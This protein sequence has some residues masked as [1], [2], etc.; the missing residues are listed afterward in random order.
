MAYRDIGYVSYKSLEKM[1][2]NRVPYR[3]NHI[4]AWP[5]G[6]RDYSDRHFRYDED[7]GVY[8]LYLGHLKTLDRIVAGHINALQYE[9]DMRI[10]KS[11]HVGR[12][13][14]DN[15]FE[16]IG[17]YSQGNF[18]FYESAFGINFYTQSSI[19][20]ATMGWRDD[21]YKTKMHPIFHGLRV[22]TETKE[23]HPSTH[24]VTLHPTLKVKEAKEYTK[25]FKEFLDVH[26][27]FLDPLEANGVAEIV[28]D[29]KSNYLDIKNVAG[30]VEDL[31]YRKL[32]ADAAVMCA[33]FRS[34]WTFRDPKTSARH[35]KFAARKM[36]ESDGAL[37]FKHMLYEKSSLFNYR[38]IP[39]GEK[40]STSKWKIRV[41]VGGVDAQRL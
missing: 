34:S 39:M 17:E 2:A 38:E 18:Q 40:L 1:R 19:G 22:N 9:Q 5:V 41:Q 23:V 36:M 26:H 27:M 7:T 21:A 16:F 32:Y 10:L 6:N 24:Y 14:P 28:E 13:H 25:Q 33:G 20:G 15:T 3:G 30:I 11:C 31:V 8:D 12:M 29:I 35:I 37:F 4:A